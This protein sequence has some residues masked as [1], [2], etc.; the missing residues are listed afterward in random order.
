MADST[1]IALV[2]EDEKAADRLFQ[3]LE[4]TMKA[5]TF[6]IDTAAVAIYK[7]NGEVI[8]KQMVHSFSENGFTPQLWE[9]LIRT[10]LS[11]WGYH[12]DDWFL[13]QFKHVF[14]LGTSA[15]LCLVKPE[16]SHGVLLRFRQFRGTLI[17][18][19]LTEEQKVLL[20]AAAS[21]RS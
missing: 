11:G 21:S 2:F 17:Y 10:L 7:Q 13:E 1:V 3:T 9:F 20:K 4:E 14:Q 8:V 6:P 19:G 16:A 18:T 12:I 15:F 5:E